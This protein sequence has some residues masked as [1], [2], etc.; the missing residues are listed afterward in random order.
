MHDIDH[1]AKTQ[2]VLS[3]HYLGN[4]WKKVAVENKGFV[5]IY[6][7]T[8]FIPVM[9]KLKFSIITPVLSHMILQKSF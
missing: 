4:G 2:D 3:S 6:F 9:A 7:K 1:F 5:F 8:L